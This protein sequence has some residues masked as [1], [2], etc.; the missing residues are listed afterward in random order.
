MANKEYI[1]P[2]C[3]FAWRADGE[4]RIYKASVSFCLV[5]VNASVGHLVFH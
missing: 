2:V 1:R 3:H 5:G 4:Q